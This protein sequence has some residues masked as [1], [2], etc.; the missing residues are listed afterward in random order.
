MTE[1]KPNPVTRR[2]GSIKFASR[3]DPIR[4]LFSGP[5]AASK[6]MRIGKLRP[7]RD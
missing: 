1:K 5:S 2:E 4:E 6:G 3:E 7:A